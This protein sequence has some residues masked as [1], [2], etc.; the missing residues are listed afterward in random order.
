MQFTPCWLCHCFRQLVIRV[1][2]PGDSSCLESSELS[3][4]FGDGTTFRNSSGVGVQCLPL[5]CCL[6]DWIITFFSFTPK[7]SHHS[8]ASKQRKR[9]LPRCSYLQ[10][11]LAGPQK[12]LTD[13]Q[14]LLPPSRCV[15]SPSGSL[16]HR[17]KTRFVPLASSLWN[18]YAWCLLWAVG[19]GFRGARFSPKPLLRPSQGSPCAWGILEHRRELRGFPWRGLYHWSKDAAASPLSGNPLHLG[20]KMSVLHPVPDCR[21]PQP[22]PALVPGALPAQPPALRPCAWG[23][24]WGRLHWWGGSFSCCAG[25]ASQCWALLP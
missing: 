15:G 2:K 24:D 7:V 3:D 18:A 21:F 20:G 12:T 22:W 17:I 1:G 8:V 5:I 4:N 19:Q 25:T 13:P 16:C 9:F 11:T 6:E 23:C 10:C 14:M